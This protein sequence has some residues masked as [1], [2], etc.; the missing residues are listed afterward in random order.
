MKNKQTN[1]LPIKKEQTNNRKK[2]RHNSVSC[3]SCQLKSSTIK[4]L[5]ENMKPDGSITV[6][7]WKSV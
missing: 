1:K 6:S 3:Y 4:V 2:E 5:Y 7:V